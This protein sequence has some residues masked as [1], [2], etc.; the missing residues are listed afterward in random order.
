MKRFEFSNFT[1]MDRPIRKNGV[2]I[3]TVEHAYQGLKTLDIE[4]RV[5]IFTAP[6]PGKAKRLGGK[7]VLRE[8][9]N[10]I[11]VDVMD[12][13]LKIK[14]ET[15]SSWRKKLD[16]TNTKLVEWNHWHDNFWGDCQCD[17]CRKFI[18]KNML[19]KLLMKIR[20]N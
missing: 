3:L 17:K 9:W 7:I 1:P 4:N 10:D 11:K 18:G 8:D 15:G 16:K 5:K 14:F 19:G 6:T 20:D 13:L 12:C 2:N